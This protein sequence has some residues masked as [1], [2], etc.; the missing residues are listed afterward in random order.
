M[1]APRKLAQPK[2]TI[3]RPGQTGG[4]NKIAD[5]V[6]EMLHGATKIHFTH[7]K[8]TSFAAHCALGEFYEAIPGLA[9]GIA[10]CYQGA[11]EQLLSFPTVEVEPILTPEDAVNY[12]RG[13]YEKVDA[14]QQECMYSEIGNDM[15]MIKSLIDK[16]KYKLLFL[17]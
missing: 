1:Q 2:S 4:G 17:K 15:D 6:A 7:L 8:T 16:T 14:A 9:D 11:T 5:L 13:L 12:L 3:K 10:E